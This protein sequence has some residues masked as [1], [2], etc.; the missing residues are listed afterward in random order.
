MRRFLSFRLDTAN[1]CLWRGEAT[2]DLTPKAFDVL[3]YLVEHA[4]RLV[5]PDELLEALWPETY[6]NPEGVR[7]YIQEIRKV[8]GDRP[9]QPVFIQ[10]LPKRGYQFVAQ[11][12]EERHAAPSSETAEAV[13]NTVGRGEALAG[14][15][16]DLRKVLDGQRQVVFVTGEAGIGKTTLLDAFQH[17]AAGDP[18]LRIARGQCIEGFG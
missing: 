5:T 10:T 18:N 15:D 17:R 1:Q 3:R 11:V 4:G 13:G 12:T 7:K 2:A 16:N 9:D 8:L 14:L 6:V